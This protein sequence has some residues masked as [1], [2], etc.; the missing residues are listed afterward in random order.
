[1]PTGSSTFRMKVDDS[2]EQTD[3]KSVNFSSLN[4]SAIVPAYYPFSS[5]FFT[6]PRYHLAT[7]KIEKNMATIRTATF[8][9]LNDPEE[10]DV[11]HRTISTDSW[12][13]ECLKFNSTRSSF[14][15][16]A[17]AMGPKM[18]L[19]AVLRQPVDRFL[20]AYIHI[21]LSPRIYNAT[22]RCFGCG[23]DMRCFVE[24]L[25]RFLFDFYNNRMERTHMNNVLADHFAPQT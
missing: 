1:M 22:G 9:Y 8:C 16:T 19:F 4:R 11:V 18:L 24:G 15:E 20:S 5:S 12:N 3:W 14:D 21:C 2:S 10:F 23:S 7:C 6:V 17:K 25:H 13:T